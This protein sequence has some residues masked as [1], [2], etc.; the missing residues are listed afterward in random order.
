MM[1]KRD[2]ISKWLTILEYAKMTNVKTACKK[3]KVSSIQFK[4]YRSRYNKHGA[5]GLALKS[6][7]PKNHRF[8]ILPK[9]KEKIIKLSHDNPGKG[10]GAL[11]K[12]LEEKGIK[13]SLDSVQTILKDNGIGHD[14][15]RWILMEKLFQEKKKLSDEQLKFLEKKNPCIKEQ[16]HFG[17]YPGDLIVQKTMFISYTN[18]NV[19]RTPLKISIIIDTYSALAFGKLYNWN[20]KQEI[21]EHWQSVMGYYYDNNLKINHIE[22]DISLIREPNLNGYIERFYKT[23]IIDFYKK[24]K[25]ND[26]TNADQLKDSFDSWLDKYNNS[27]EYHEGYKNYGKAPMKLHQKYVQRATRL[28]CKS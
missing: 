26:Y 2:N 1:T 11:L 22:K 8:E 14:N 21:E 17:K 16:N 13:I 20:H 6:R 3:Y 19:S 25:F 12:M 18:N 24:I 28:T 5:G 9:T 7:R 23:F 10:C 15:E 4:R 27:D